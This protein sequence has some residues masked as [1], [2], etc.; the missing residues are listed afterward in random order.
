MGKALD[1]RIGCAVFTEV[2]KRLKDVEHPNT[3]FGAGTVQ[4]EVGLRGAKTSAELI[5]PDVAFVT[6]VSIA[7]D[8][9]G[10]MESEAQAKLGKGPSIVVL[11]GSLIPNSKLRDL[12]VRTAEESN[13]PHQFQ[14][15]TRGGTDG[16]RIHLHGVGVPSLVVGVPT[17][18][19]HSHVGVFDHSDFENAVTLLVEV[20]KKLD[21][22][23]VRELRP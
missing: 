1:D 17:R 2:I 12:V 20:I 9:P 7:G 22:E 6:E 3:V 10:V 11:D 4:E 23:T 13:I 14:A 16:G 19:I 5:N 21:A 15:G 8:T 18:Y